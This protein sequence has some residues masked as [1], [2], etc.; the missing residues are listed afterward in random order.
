VRAYVLSGSR[1]TTQ[2]A[3]NGFFR[4]LSHDIGAELQMWQEFIAEIV[5]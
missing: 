2:S 1:L 5:R 4:V 3:P